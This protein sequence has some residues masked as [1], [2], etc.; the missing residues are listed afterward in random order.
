M[1]TFDKPIVIQYKDR[2]A[3]Q[4]VTFQRLHAHI[5][6]TSS[7]EYT[8]AGSTRSSY[9]LT[10]TVRFNPE[11]KKVAHALQDYR[12]RLV[13][14]DISD[15]DAFHAVKGWFGVEVERRKTLALETSA[16]LDHAFAFLEETFL[17]GQELVMFVTEITAG[18]D[19]SWF[20]ENFGCDAYFRH[21][22]EL[23]FDETQQR[24]RDSIAAAKQE[25]TL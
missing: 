1:V 10:F 2:E 15:T 13:D 8:T 25:E 20:V 6:T 19:T 24:I 16:M 11:L 22:K 7:N 14:E 12:S 18:F 4:W 9:S 21:N 5:N 23:L 3:R 17:Q